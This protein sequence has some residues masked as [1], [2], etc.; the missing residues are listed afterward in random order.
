MRGQ[1]EKFHHI[2]TSTS[3]I[4]KKNEME[5]KLSLFN[6]KQEFRDQSDVPIWKC[7][8]L[9]RHNITYCGKKQS[10]GIEVA[11]CYIKIIYFLEKKKHLKAITIKRS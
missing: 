4:N 11:F 6:M 5:M 9:E 3:W 2:E 7:T 8:Q 10:A 1:K